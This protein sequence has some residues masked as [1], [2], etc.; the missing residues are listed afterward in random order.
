[1]ELPPRARRIQKDRLTPSRRNGTTSAHAEN[2]PINYLRVR[3]EYPF[4]EFLRSSTLELPPR[5]RRIR[6]RDHKDRASP[7]TTSAHAENT[8]SNYS[9]VT[10]KRNYLRARGEYHIPGAGDTGPWELPPRTRRIPLLSPVAAQRRGTT[11][12]HAENTEPWQPQPLTWGNYLRARGEYR[13]AKLG[14]R[15]RGEL[16]PR[17]RRIQDSRPWLITYLGTTSA[18]AE[19]T[20]V[21]AAPGASGG[22]Y[23]RARGEY[24]RP[25]HP[26]CDSGE[27]PPRTRRIL[28]TL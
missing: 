2:T 5:A 4:R 14:R 24:R 28:S 19:N 11:S 12:A 21:L 18:H 15:S 25:C 8:D 23:L 7:G 9:N 20:H 1:M 10:I 27:L 26:G 3:G 16:P 22:N 6:N 17:T 13:Y